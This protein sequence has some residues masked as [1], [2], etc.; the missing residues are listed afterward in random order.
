MNMVINVINV[1]NIVNVINKEHSVS[2]V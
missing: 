1:I 2:E